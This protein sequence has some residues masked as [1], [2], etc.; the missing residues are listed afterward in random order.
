MPE[1]IADRDYFLDGEGNLTTDSTVAAQWLAKK[2]G[3]ISQENQDK[4]GIPTAPEKEKVAH[5]EDDDNDD[6]K[7]ESPKA[8]KKASPSKNKGAK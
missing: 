2:D 8:N 7:S 3:L 1:V 4:Y 5:A 6:E